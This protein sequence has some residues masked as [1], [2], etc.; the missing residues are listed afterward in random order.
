MLHELYVISGNQS[1]LAMI[2]IFTFLAPTFSHIP[3]KPLVLAAALCTT[4]AQA[5]RAV[6]QDG[7]RCLRK[8][9]WGKITYLKCF[10]TH[11]WVK[12]LAI[13]GARKEGPPRGTGGIAGLLAPRR[14]RSENNVL[15][16]SLLS[17]SA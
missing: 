17:S 14:S 4:M 7:E 12:P 11:I 2:F 8:K 13:P 9:G 10:S 5:A 15:V 16:F 6:M 1:F 3:L